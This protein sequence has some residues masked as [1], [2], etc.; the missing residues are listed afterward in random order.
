MLKKDNPK[1]LLS[2]TLNGVKQTPRFLAGAAD[3]LE[4]EREDL[5]D[6]VRTSPD[7]ACD[8]EHPETIARATELSGPA[9]SGLGPSRTL[10]PPAPSRPSP[11]LRTSRGAVRYASSLSL[12]RRSPGALRIGG[13]RYYRHG[14]TD[15]S[16]DARDHCPG[17]I[18]AHPERH[19]VESSYTGR[20]T[21]VFVEGMAHNFDEALR[22]MEMA[23]TDCPNWLWETD[24]WPDEAPTAPTS[25]GGLHG[26][27]P[28]FL[29]YHALSCL[30]YDLSGGFE[31]WEP[32]PPFDDNTRSYPNRVF[33]NAELLGYVEYCRGRVRQTL[34]ALTGD[35]AA[36][37]LPSA[38]RYGGTLLGVIVASVPLHVV[39]HASQI[40][41]FL[42]A[43]GVKVQPMPGDGGY[44]V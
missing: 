19:H 21:S 17:R 24:L 37:P 16:S 2:V 12:R 22:L 15:P 26:S 44:A 42:T 8:Y 3:V 18:E 36:R 33:T 9:S 23:L 14:P 4:A 20:V 7:T 28:W 32:P 1:R 40:R 5:V 29:A 31:P 11:G 38:H 30:D 39:E 35:M 25:H 10:A 43:A 13:S 41:Q 34:D 6:A 27:A